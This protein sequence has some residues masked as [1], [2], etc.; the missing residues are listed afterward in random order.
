MSMNKKLFIPIVLCSVIVVFVIFTK[1]FSQNKITIEWE[2]VEVPSLVNDSIELKVYVE[3]SGSMNA[4]MCDG[5]HLKDAV[6]DYVSDLK[7]NTD[8]CSL[9]YINSQIIPCKVSL[10]SYIKDLTPASFSKAGGN[11]ANTDLRD[12]FK[13]IMSNQTKN[14]ISVFVSD[15]ILDIPQKATAYFGNCQV[16]MKNIF[17]E[18]LEK[19]PN[20][21]VQIMKLQS[22]FEG[23]WYCGKN[24]E[25]LSNTKRPYYIWVI[26]DKNILK[27]INKEVPVND[28]IGGIQEYCAFSTSQS[29]P[30]N[31]N[32]TRYVVNHT[33]KI[34]IEILADLHGS[35]Q[36]ELT[37]KALE[38]YTL[39]NPSQ[40]TLTSVLPI[41]TKGSRY[42]HVLNLEISN[43][44]TIR[45]VKVSFSYP[46]LAKW[47][48]ISNDNTGTNV[49]NNLNKTTGILYLIKGVA[50]A[51]KNHTNYGNVEFNLKN[52]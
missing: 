31:F 35:L 47:V 24:K 30:I 33:D 48:L 29:I 51:Y 22:K 38:N 36:N 27:E 46:Y 19:N 45:D 15:C 12:I 41:T 44:Q 17:N 28:I 32:K 21:G 25:L 37:I 16:S 20:L 26:G 18:A 4:Y 10:D 52:K 43:P 34:N 13:K 39:S 23:Y 7:K 11:L 3:N 5:S 42:S 2:N 14:T 9:Y 40:M 50:E 6:Y 1:I 8:S 49:K